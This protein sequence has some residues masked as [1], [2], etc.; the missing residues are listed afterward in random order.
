MG[1]ALAQAA[2]RRGARVTLVV[3]PT[4]EA[5]PRRLKNIRVIPVVSALE[6]RQKVRACRAGADAVI[7]AAA[8]A[9]YRPAVHHKRKIKGKPSVLTLKLIKNPDI[10][11]EVARPGLGRP[12]LV[13]GFALE[14]DHLMRNAGK[15][16]RDKNLDWIIA[17]RPC[18]LGSRGGLVTLLS[19]W[20]DRIPLG[21]KPKGRLAAAIWAALVPSR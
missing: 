19:R 11:A 4:A 14:T 16:L 13:I 3:G 12:K 21:P 8:V 5:W 15:K 7:G 10:L 6:M 20:K 18:N 1:I 17:N 9:D 2:A